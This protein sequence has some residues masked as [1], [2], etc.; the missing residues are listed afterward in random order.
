MVMQDLSTIQEKDS[1]DNSKTRVSQ[2]T[3]TGAPKSRIKLKN[4]DYIKKSVSDYEAQ[5]NLIKE[6]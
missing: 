6:I 3:I 2:D 4:T 1:G 5:D